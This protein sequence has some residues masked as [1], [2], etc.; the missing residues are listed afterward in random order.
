MIVEIGGK[1]IEVQIR[2][3]LQHWWAELSEKFSDL[4][5]PAIK[6][7]GGDRE[8]L[9]SLAVASEEI[10]KVETDEELLHDIVAELARR[11]G[12]SEDVGSNLMKARQSIAARRKHVIKLIAG[13][14]EIVSED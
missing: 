3:S 7:G 12:M 11:G 2:T 14:G 5:D 10:V 9:D 4:I 13:M 8:A 6:Y 1:S